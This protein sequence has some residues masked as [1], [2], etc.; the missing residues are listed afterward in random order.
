VGF[1]PST[2]VFLGAM[3]FLINGSRAWKLNAVITL[4]FTFGAWYVFVRLFQ[5]NLP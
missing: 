3:L 2:L 4:G 1:I 5:I